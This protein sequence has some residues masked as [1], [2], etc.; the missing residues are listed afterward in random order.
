MDRAISVHIDVQWGHT[1]LQ[2][3]PD[4]FIISFVTG[5][6]ERR[7]FSDLPSV[8][9]F[10]EWVVIFLV[11]WQRIGLLL[12]L[13]IL[14]HLLCLYVGSCGI[15]LDEDSNNFFIAIACCPQERAPTT[16]LEEGIGLFVKPKIDFF[17]I[18]V[19]AGLE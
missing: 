11:F 8:L 14:Y 9:R 15:S 2:Q 3:E 12:F 13:T 7:I 5:P 4:N 16:F 1:Y 19:S 18:A 6:M 10:Y 17:N